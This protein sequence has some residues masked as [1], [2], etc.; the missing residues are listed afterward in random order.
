MATRDDIRS[1]RTSPGRHRHEHLQ[2]QSR[3]PASGACG[4]VSAAGIQK[5][6]Q[7]EKLPF[8]SLYMSLDSAH[9]RDVPI[10]A[11]GRMQQKHARAAGLLD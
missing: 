2:P 4:E 10:A 3:T 5:R 6:A 11:G 7:N 9:D 1:L 8:W